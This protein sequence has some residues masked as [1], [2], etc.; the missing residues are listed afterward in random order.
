MLPPVDVGRHGS[1]FVDGERHVV[2]IDSLRE[3]SPLVFTSSSGVRRIDV[4]RV[5]LEHRGEVLNTLVCLVKLFK[6]ASSHIVS[7]SMQI[8]Q[9][10]QPVA[11]L[12]RLLEKSLLEI[13]G[14]PDE[15]CLAMVGVLIQ[16]LAAYCN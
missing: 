13:A 8:I 3:V 5:D 9:L 12:Y 2:V 16:L 6:C 10:H 1:L 11:I 14:G 7:S 15:Q 4:V